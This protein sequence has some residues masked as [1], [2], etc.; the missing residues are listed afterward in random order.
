MRYALPALAPPLIWPRTGTKRF[1]QIRRR[2]SRGRSPSRPAAG[3]DGCRTACARPLCPNTC[4]H[5]TAGLTRTLFGR[6]A[7]GLFH[8]SP[9][10][11]SWGFIVG[12]FAIVKTVKPSATHGAQSSMEASSKA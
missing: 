11:T 8:A 10:K 2:L 5:E 4:S 9:E 6:Y 3:R 7:M 12:I 1:T